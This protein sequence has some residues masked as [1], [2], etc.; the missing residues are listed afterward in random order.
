[1]FSEVES[2]K[3]FRSDRSDAESSAFSAVSS[4]SE[5]EDLPEEEEPPAKVKRRRRAKSLDVVEEEAVVEEEEAATSDEEEA[6]V[7]EKEESATSDEEEAVASEQEEEDNVAVASDEEEEEENA[8]VASDESEEEGAAV[9]SEEEEEEAE[10][11]LAATPLQNAAGTSDEEESASSQDE[12]EVAAAASDE[13]ESNSDEER[14]VVEEPRSSSED[15][16]GSGEEAIAAE[17]EEEG[18]GGDDSKEILTKVITISDSEEDE[19]VA[20]EDDNEEADSDD[21]D[22]D[23]EEAPVAADMFNEDDQAISEHFWNAEEREEDEARDFA[24][25]STEDEDE[26]LHAIP[27]PYHAIANE[28]STPKQR[29]TRGRKEVAPKAHEDDDDDGVLCQM[30]QLGDSTTKNRI[31]L[32]DTCNLGHH[33]KCVGLRLLPKRSQKWFCPGCV[34]VKD[35][36]ATMKSLLTRV[37]HACEY[38]V[39]HAAAAAAEKWSA[40]VPLRLEL[41]EEQAP[42]LGGMMNKWFATSNGSGAYAC[43][44]CGCEFDS[45]ANTSLRDLVLHATTPLVC[46]MTLLATSSE[47]QGFQGTDRA[48]LTKLWQR[49]LARF[50]VPA[51]ASSLSD[52]LE[53][54]S[55]RLQATIQH[56]L[57]AVVAQ[58]KRD[59]GGGDTGGD[60]IKAYLKELIRLANCTMAVPPAQLAV[61]DLVAMEHRVLT[62]D[63]FE[64]L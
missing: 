33:L 49:Y 21:E 62:M 36:E 50:P 30:C 22:E 48:R 15:E 1:M 57:G 63:P 58:F 6:A 18:A 9:A 4:A 28:T 39:L 23:D 32:C 8:A 42:G 54:A 56:R 40:I 25:E 46:K 34:L 45:D 2:H 37:V 44:A 59:T 5:E 3:S 51:P 11:T 27:F 16:D 24:M 52:E 14:P 47:R 64:E 60:A 41:W 53:Q 17:S 35:V 38:R 10:D 61:K 12:A 29:K 43:K 26:E 31:L 13:E 20:L 7:V 55:T 19:A